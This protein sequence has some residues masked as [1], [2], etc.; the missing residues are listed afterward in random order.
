MPKDLNLLRLS[1]TLTAKERAKLVITLFLKRVEEAE[2]DEQQSGAEVVPSTGAEIDQLLAALPPDQGREYRSY[3]TL[4][5]FVIQD[6]LEG[7]TKATLYLSAMDAQIERVR[8]DLLLA[9]LVWYALD[10]LRWQ[11][12]VVT[13]A[14]YEVAV[15]RAK[16][17][18]RDRI[19]ELDGPHNLAE[20]E[21]FARLLRDGALRE[22]HGEEDDPLLDDW[23][24][25]IG[26]D[27]KTDAE[28]IRESLASLK[29]GIG[30]YEREKRLTGQG[31]FWQEYQRYAGLSEAQLTEVIKQERGEELQR[32]SQAEVARWQQAVDAE[33]QRLLEAVK[34]GT[35]RWAKGTAPDYDH[36]KKRWLTHEVNGIQAGSYYDWPDRHQKF[37]GEPGAATRWHPLAEDSL[38]LTYYKGK[39]TTPHEQFNQGT[40]WHPIAIA[41]PYYAETD[42]RTS[43]EWTNR[44]AEQVSRLLKMLLPVE[45]KSKPLDDST[46]LCL[47]PKVKASLQNFV[48][49]V[50]RVINRIHTHI[51]LIEAIETKHFD[52][53]PL[54]SLDP[55]HPL[56]ESARALQVID[57]VVSQ[58][59]ARLRDVVSSFN[60][61]NQGLREFACPELE[62][63]LLTTE[64]TIDQEWVARRLALAEEN[65]D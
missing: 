43:P 57:E 40:D 18:A 37:G 46:L 29:M 45:M 33:R 60:R 6:V 53:M 21:A 41:T 10:L 59:N 42:P 1:A 65:A 16:Q 7:I 19:L 47:K 63:F 34:A 22:W 9:P 48:Q 28:L 2:Q 24:A 54:V 38:E 58:H 27:A 17:Q 55:Q 51:A 23:L 52:G 30:Q 50:R 15:A 13:R 64:P 11:P 49:D 39:L 61:L 35:L 8:R 44:H 20:E 32:P 4:F 62:E 31:H 5:F 12:R 36:D 25:Y 26:R 3:I 14:E 56:G